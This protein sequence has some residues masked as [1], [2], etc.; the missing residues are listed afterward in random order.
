MILLYIDSKNAHYTICELFETE[1]MLKYRI[2]P[3]TQEHR[4]TGST[5]I[6]LLERGNEVILEAI[7]ELLL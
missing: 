6:R 2:R 3:G 7:E 1:G 4:I 5:I